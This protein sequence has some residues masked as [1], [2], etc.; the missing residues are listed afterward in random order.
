MTAAEIDGDPEPD[1]FRGGKMRGGRMKMGI[2]GHDGSEAAINMYLDKTAEGLNS[3]DIGEMSGK[4]AHI[5]ITR[6]NVPAVTSK[7]EVEALI[8]KK[9]NWV[10]KHPEEK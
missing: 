3:G 8:G 7:E 5:M 10:G 1:Y 6:Y 9:I 2:V 4:I